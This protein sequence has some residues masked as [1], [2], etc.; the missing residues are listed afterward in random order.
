[1]YIV[2]E[3]KGFEKFEEFEEFEGF[4]KFEG[5]EGF[6]GFEEFEGSRRYGM[7]NTPFEGF[8]LLVYFL[9]VKDILHLSKKQN[10]VSLHQ[11]N[12]KL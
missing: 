9:P 2:E 7:S 4:E 8:W 11:K 3:F 1:L 12:A 6:E 10:C 5:F